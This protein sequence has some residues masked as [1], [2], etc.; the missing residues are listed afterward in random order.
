MKLNLLE[1]ILPVKVKNEPE[2]TQYE[3]TS[4]GNIVIPEKISD[5]NAYLLAQSVSELF[6]PIDFYADRLSKLRYFIADKEGN[7]LGKNQYNRLLT[8]INPFFSFNDLIYQYVFSYLGAGNGITYLNIPSIYS[9]ISPN[10]ITRVDVLQPDLLALSEYTNVSILKIS[11]LNSLIKRATYNDSTN[12]I[13]EIDKLRIDNYGLKRQPYS[14]V[15]SSSPLLA[16]NKSI[17]T[18]LSVYSARYNV[19]ANNGA[20]G[21]LSRKTVSG[22][23]PNMALEM[24]LSEGD[25]RQKMIDDL[26]NRNGLTGKRNIFGLS[27]VPLEFVKTLASIAEL[28]PLEET[29]ENAIKIASVFQIPPVLVPR[30]DQ[31]TYDN[32]ENAEKIV[33]ENGLLSMAGVVCENWTR[34]LK[35]D[36]TPYKIGVDL[37]DISSMLEDEKLEIEVKQ[38]SFNYYKGLFDSGII[39]YNNYLLNLEQQPVVGGDKYIQDMTKIP[40]AV[41]LGVGGTQAIQALIADP[42]ITPESKKNSLVVIYGLTEDEANKITGNGT[43]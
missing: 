16:A 20:A 25:G 29:L 15:L 7:E 26:N 21:Y 41:K 18:L 17:D 39:T 11:D 22:T 40:Y 24:M 34:I 38:N 31:S 32:Q 12:N 35:L 13:L 28:L 2:P 14:K 30:K 9:N 8:D 36:T 1:R 19:Y 42:N 10:N 4:L 5:E 6:F 33:W 27:S 3:L 37:S 23:N 43:N